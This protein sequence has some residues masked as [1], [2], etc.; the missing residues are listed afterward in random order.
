MTIRLLCQS[1]YLIK[2]VIE[3]PKL[4]PL[5][6]GYFLFFFLTHSASHSTVSSERIGSGSTPNEIEGLTLYEDLVNLN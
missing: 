1:K 6:T 5:P 3:K 4:I 2:S